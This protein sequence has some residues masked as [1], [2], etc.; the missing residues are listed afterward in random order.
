[1]EIIKET[2]PHIKRKDNLL[3]MMLDVIIALLPTIVLSFIAYGVHYLKNYLISVGVM[4]FAEFVFVLIKNHIPYDGK[5]H[6]LKERLLKGL[7]EYRVTDFLVPAVSALIYS[8]IMPAGASWYAV[9]IGAIFGIVVG[10]LIF[11]GTGNN[12]FN[13]AAVGMVAAKLCF[14]S[15]YVNLNPSFA[16]VS[17]S[18]TPLGNIN[19]LAF[20][21]INDYS[22]LDLFL[23]RIGGTSGEAFKIAILAGFV[24]LLI[25][26]DIDWRITLSYIG[27]FAFM[28]LFA[29]IIVHS[30]LPE[31]G[32]FHFLA[33]QLLS[34]GLLFGAVFMITDPVTSPINAPARWIYG[35]LAGV[36]TVIIRLFG[37][38]P[39]GVGFSILIANACASALEYHAWSSSRWKRWHVIALSS[40]IVLPTIIMVLALLF[41]GKI[42]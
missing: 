22:L 6:S 35:A 30:K 8:L 27:S 31:V 39:E 42:A 18:A 28:M 13:P 17:V 2:S 23:G 14:G 10:K 25:R 41:G 20:S 38:L 12:I 1:M 11:G 7:K 40:I 36:L 29:G 9:L 34:G 16:D 37:A 21:N 5:K 33:Y 26:R 24:Y 3:W 19:G 4:C 32:V 15:T